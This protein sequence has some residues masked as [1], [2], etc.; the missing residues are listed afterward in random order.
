[1]PASSP[2]IGAYMTMIG[3]DCFARTGWLIHAL[4]ITNATSDA[5]Y[6]TNQETALEAAFVI[7]LGVFGCAF[8]KWQVN[9]TANRIYYDLV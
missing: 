7:V 8:Q 1:M 6:H 5:Y 2:M 9:A 4:D 3:V